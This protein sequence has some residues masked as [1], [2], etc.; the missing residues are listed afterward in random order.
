[1]VAG[2][3]LVEYFLVHKNPI[4]KTAVMCTALC[5][6]YICYSFRTHIQTQY[7]SR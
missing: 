4:L 5:L 3:F 6:F 1:M 7:S 2:I